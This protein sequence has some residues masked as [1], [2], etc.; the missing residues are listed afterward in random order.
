[1]LDLSSPLF[2]R[3]MCSHYS[4]RGITLWPHSP[5]FFKLIIKRVNPKTFQLLDERQNESA[6]VM[7]GRSAA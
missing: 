1:M 6:A 3:S 7:V 2:D 5:P 4:V